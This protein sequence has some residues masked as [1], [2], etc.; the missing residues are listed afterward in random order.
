MPLTGPLHSRGYIGPHLGFSRPPPL[1]LPL[2]DK[3]GPAPLPRYIGH[4]RRLDVYPRLTQPFGDRLARCVA[5][6]HRL[7]HRN[8]IASSE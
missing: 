1:G 8:E 3:L 4:S 5:D 6:Q 7:P 2:G